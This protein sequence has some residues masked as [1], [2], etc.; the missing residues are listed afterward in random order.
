MLLLMFNYLPAVFS[1]LLLI[2]LFFSIEIMF[3]SYLNLLI[4][5]GLSLHLYHL[6]FINIHLF[7]FLI[8]S[9]Y[10]F[11]SLKGLAQ[12]STPSHSRILFTRL[13]NLIYNFFNCSIV[14]FFGK[15]LVI[16]FKKSYHYNQNSQYNLFFH[17]IFQD[18]FNKE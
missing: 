17:L 7:F 10:V 6:I 11:N 2:Y 14:L 15:N 18:F 12:I 13:V 16:Y 5:K 4:E 8:F 3:P 9:L 1:G